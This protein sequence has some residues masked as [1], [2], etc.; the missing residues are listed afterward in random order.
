[1]GYRVGFP[2][3]RIAALAGL[4]LKL[5]VD[6]IRDDEAKVFVATSPDMPGLIAEAETVDQ[7]LLNLKAAFT[8]LMQ[9]EFSAP[10]EIPRAEF[11]LKPEQLCAA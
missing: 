9:D 5:R 6:V 4:R 8:D 11:G 10:R 2:G 3:W 1:M 7:L